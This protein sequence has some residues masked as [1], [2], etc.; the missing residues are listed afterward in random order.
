MPVYDREDS[1]ILKN[2]QQ[3][4]DYFKNK[5]GLEWVNKEIAMIEDKFTDKRNKLQK[6]VHDSLGKDI[7]R[8]KTDIERLEDGKVEILKRELKIIIKDIPLADEFVD[9]ADKIKRH[10]ENISLLQTQGLDK[11]NSFY[12]LLSDV[13]DNKF[14]GIFL[15]PKNPVHWIIK[16]IIYISLLIVLKSIL[17]L[18]LVF[19]ESYYKIKSKEIKEIDQAIDKLNNKNTVLEEEIYK[20]TLDLEEDIVKYRYD[21]DVEEEI[22]EINKQI[23]L[24]E[25]RID[26]LEKNQNIKLIE[27]NSMINW[28]LKTSLEVALKKKQSIEKRDVELGLAYRAIKRNYSKIDKDASIE[29]IL[30][31]LKGYLKS[32]KAKDDSDA[33]NIYKNRLKEEKSDIINEK[34]R[35]EELK[36]YK[37]RMKAKEEQI[38]LKRIKK[39]EQEE[40]QRQKLEE[41]K[42]ER[43]R[44]KLLKEE[45]ERIY[46]LEEGIKELD[47]KMSNRNINEYEKQDI[48]E[49]RSFLQEQR[50]ELIK[51]RSTR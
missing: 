36:R 48:M 1:R 49:E 46:R 38:R 14:I 32:G 29:E 12:E 37:E 47:K 41:E 17:F 5:E 44:K 28:E 9:L 4:K 40:A 42:K 34:K 8:N 21:L 45:K 31:E 24:I 11:R 2:D 22:D 16:I 43:E 18:I 27:I 7:S 10:E 20:E 13:A 15:Y 35:K 25:K 23:R 51:R 26:K 19:F 33:I 30:D 39:E 3:F 50:L 6:N